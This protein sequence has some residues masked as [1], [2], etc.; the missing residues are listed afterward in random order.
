MYD[1]ENSSEEDLIKLFTQKGIKLNNTEN[2]FIEGQ[3]NFSSVKQF[4]G[5]ESQ[6]IIAID[7]NQSFKNKNVNNHLYT[8]FTRTL[9]TFYI[10]HDKNFY[11]DAK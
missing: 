4:R 1:D 3:I 10:Y 7:F 6:I 8:A 5:L 2:M 11:L 9:D